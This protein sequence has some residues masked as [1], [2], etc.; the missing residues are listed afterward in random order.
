MSSEQ[1]LQLKLRPWEV[2]DLPLLERLM[3]DPDMTRYLG[4]PETPEKIRNRHEKY[5]AAKGTDHTRVFV[6]V[7]SPDSAPV[8]SV[9]YWERDQQGGQVWEVGWATL[10]EFQGQGIASRATQM[11]SDRARAEKRHRYMYAFPSVDNAASNAICRK[12]GF[13]LEKEEEFEYPKGHWMRC[14][15]W[16]LDLFG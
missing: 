2:G 9:I 6:V 10:P 7:T 1:T 3:G 5:V 11:V 4:G 14:N 12:L 16:R 13:E 15:N 8:A